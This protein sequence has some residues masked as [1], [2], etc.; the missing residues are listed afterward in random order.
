MLFFV[1]PDSNG[2]QALIQAE[3]GEQDRLV[4][5]KGSPVQG[6][7]A[8]R[9]QEEEHARYALLVKGEILAR[10]EGR[11]QEPRRIRAQV[12]HKPCIERR[13]VDH[14]RIALG[15]GEMR[16]AARLTLYGGGDIAQRLVHLPVQFGA[17]GAHGAADVGMVA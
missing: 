4:K 2:Q 7:A 10:E 9:S 8:A 6:H 12:G 11:G 17:E 13:V 14:G 1:Q 3:V 15:K 16:A 5:I